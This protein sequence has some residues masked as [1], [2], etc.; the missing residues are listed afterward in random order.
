MATFKEFYTL[1]KLQEYPFS[2]FTTENEISR[3]KDTFTPPNDYET[4]IENFSQKNSIILIG[5][6][7]TGKTALSKDIINKADVIKTLVTKITD[8]SALEI[9]YKLVDFYK[10]LISNIAI[11]LF[12]SLTNKTERISKLDK[13][14]KL[15]LSYLLKNFVPQ[16][17]KRLLRE[18]I[19]KLQIPFFTRIYKRFGGFIRSVLNYGASTGAIF[20]DEYIAKHFKG[21]PSIA[22]SIQ[23]KEFFPE[24]PNDLEV[25]FID[26][27][28]TYQLL[29]RVLKLTQY[30]QFDNVLVVFDRVDE[31][32]RFSNDADA[33][34]EFILPILKD[35]NLLLEEKLQIIF[36]TWST[37][38]NFIKDKVRT[39][40]HY[41]PY[42]KWTTDDL[43]RVLNKRLAAYSNNA[44][45]DY[46]TLFDPTVSEN[47][48]NQV[49]EIAN[50]NP[51]DLWHTFNYLF[52]AQ[53]EVDPTS[54]KITSE[55][56]L[57][58][59]TEFVKTFN[60]YEY[61]PKKANSRKNTMDIY[62]Y[63]KHLLK[64]ESEVFTKNQLNERAQTGSSTNNYIVG[65]ERIGLIVSDNQQSGT[66][67][68]KIKDPK[69]VYALKNALD[70]K[71][72]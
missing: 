8:F 68:Y 23:I 39:Q 51:R 55:A 38:F 15:L 70:I 54:N 9:D 24:L 14:D 36:S 16:I 31:D 48:I 67:S 62:S 33:I 22:Q 10:F 58:A 49:F 34:S 12:D 29:L 28:T 18:K 3:F 63:V 7:G 59:L 11:N 43:T 40:K 6:R 65:M 5:D 42:L 69:V 27:K 17:S 41:C 37:P 45:S 64:L 1:F 50:R 2:S 21:L 61:Y 72:E 71:R 53:F 46:R 25:Q 35:N 19:E 52:Q 30:L 4:I 60:Y 47:E 66:V 13:E 57:R 44:L 32:S 20:I 26:Q 56:V